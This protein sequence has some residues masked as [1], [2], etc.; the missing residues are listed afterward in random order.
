MK[1]TILKL[2]VMIYLRLWQLVQDMSYM[3]RSL[4]MDSI[5]VIRIDER[6]QTLP[7]RYIPLGRPVLSLMNR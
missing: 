6:L 1:Q 7:H 3:I 2:E 5:S 4:F